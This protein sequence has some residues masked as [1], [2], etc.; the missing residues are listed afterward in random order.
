MAFRPE[1]PVRAFRIADSRHPLFDGTGAFLNGGRW[2]RKGQRVIYAALTY[3]GSLLEI[4][5]HSNLGRIPKTHAFIEISIPRDMAIEYVRIEEVPDWDAADML[6][7]REFGD[8]W[9]RDRRTA[10]LVVPSMVTCGME[11]NVV[12]NQTHPEFELIAATE[13][14]PVKWDPRVVRDSKR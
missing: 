7:A 14:A 11:S 1:G 2:N 12:I 6:A 10:V 13:P 8:G 9:Y 4:F 5:A 3:A